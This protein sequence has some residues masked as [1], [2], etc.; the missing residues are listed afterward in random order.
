MIIW[1]ENTSAHTAPNVQFV[2]IASLQQIFQQMQHIMS[3]VHKFLDEQGS[4]EV[5]VNYYV[6][7]KSDM[8]FTHV[9]HCNNKHSNGKRSQRHVF[10]CHK[11]SLCKLQFTLFTL[12]TMSVS[13]KIPTKLSIRSKKSL[14]ESFLTHSSQTHSCI[15]WLIGGY[16]TFPSDSEAYKNEGWLKQT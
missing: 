10:P 12:I 16:K 6:S 7:Q 9:L 2:P 5:S 3:K 14:M 15:R 8:L 13:M 11:L 1:I 4:V